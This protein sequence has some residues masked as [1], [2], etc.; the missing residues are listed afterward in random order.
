[1]LLQTDG[2]MLASANQQIS[3]PGWSAAMN[4]GE[5]AA[6][7]GF[8]LVSVV[9][10][11]FAAFV[12]FNIHW[13]FMPIT[14][15]GFAFLAGAMVGSWWCPLM[16]G[17][18]PIGVGIAAMAEAPQAMGSDWDA[19]ITVLA[20]MGVLIAGMLTFVSSV[21]GVVVSATRRPL[22]RTW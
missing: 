17:V 6:A 2:G 15:L 14:L 18:L 3:R 10:V 21:A 20:G 12:G 8:S 5:H 19:D 4:A 22:P 16:L 13:L 9:F 1:M 7:I 11:Y